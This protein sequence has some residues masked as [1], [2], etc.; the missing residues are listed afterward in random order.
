M[1]IDHIK[2]V[3]ISAVC[4]AIPTDKLTSEDFYNYL[5]RD[6]VDRFV[7]DSGV[8]QK[9]YS[10]NR[11]TITSDLCFEA[12]E[13]I[14][15]KKNG[16]HIVVFVNANSFIRNDKSIGSVTSF[17]DMTQEKKDKLLIEHLAYYDTLTDLP[18]RQLL[19]N[20]LSISIKESCRSHDFGGLL[21]IDLDYFKT[22]NDTYGHDIGDK[23]LQEVA[24]RLQEHLRT[25]D[26]V[27][28]FGGDEFVVYIKNAASDDAHRYMDEFQREISHLM[29]SGGEY[30][31]VSASAGGVVFIGEG[32]DFVSLCRSADNM[33][34]DVKR[35][36]KG[37]FKIKGAKKA[38]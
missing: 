9:F 27:A 34:Y 29:M 19:L 3:K 31:T 12:A 24:S 11:K 25:C 30:V 4:C 7:K 23:L 21:F 2:N 18:N 10:K 6:S 13:E 5:D 20:R 16:E 17:R 28:R 38:C 35:N 33:L 32:E 1:A 26:T 14:F 8:K 15:R 22:L 37:T 36:G